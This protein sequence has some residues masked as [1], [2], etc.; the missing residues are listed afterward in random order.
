MTDPAVRSPQ[1]ALP[2]VACLTCTYGRFQRMRECLAFFLAQDYPAKRLFILNNHPVPLRCELPDVT[3]FNEPSDEPGIP[4]NRLLGKVGDEFEF[5]HTWDDDDAWLPWHLSQAVQQ[6]A[7]ARRGEDLAKGYDRIDVHSTIPFGWKPARSWIHFTATGEYK[8]NVN[9]Y[10][11]SMILARGFVKHHGYGTASGNEHR[12]LLDALG[13]FGLATTEVGARASYIYSWRGDFTH[14][15]A[16]LGSSP[17]ETWDA[18]L[19]QRDAA[20]RKLQT[21]PG[22]GKTPLTPA[23]IRPRYRDLLAHCRSGLSEYEALELH[24]LLAR[25]CDGND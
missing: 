22:D 15:S 5:V 2:L 19:A 14:A 3:V 6:L 25:Y 13:E 12:K 8:L 7:A 20:W 18:T 4:R 11:A 23:D 16:P 1:S 17:R 24:Q 9:N 21:D 10:E